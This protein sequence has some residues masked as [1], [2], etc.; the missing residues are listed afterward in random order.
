[1]VAARITWWAL[2]QDAY[3]NTNFDSEKF[4]EFEQMDKLKKSTQKA[5]D[6]LFAGFK[7]YLTSQQQKR[8][9]ANRDQEELLGCEDGRNKGG[10]KTGQPSKVDSISINGTYPGYKNEKLKKTMSGR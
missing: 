9:L 2:N 8:W 4:E 5:R 7:K 10:C 1:M 3:S 6:R